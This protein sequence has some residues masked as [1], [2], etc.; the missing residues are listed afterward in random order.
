MPMPHS[1]ISCFRE[2][3]RQILFV[4]GSMPFVTM[5]LTPAAFARG[6]TADRIPGI[7]A[8]A[9][10]HD[11]VFPREFQADPVRPGIDAVRHDVSHA[12]SFRPGD[13]SIDIRKEARMVKVGM[14]VDEHAH[15]PWKRGAPL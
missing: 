3:S 12:G 1:T 10:L 7:V 15:G 5:C 14:D 4:R 6:M 11:V 13:D 9:S 8:H 2:S